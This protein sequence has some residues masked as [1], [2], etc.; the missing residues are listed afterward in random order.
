LHTDLDS[1][2]YVNVNYEAGSNSEFV[3]GTRVGLLSDSW[4]WMN[5]IRTVTA[6]KF[7]VIY[8]AA[9][10]GK[11]T[12]AHEICNQLQ[13]KRMLGA[14]FFFL[15]DDANRGSTAKVVPTI[16]Y[17]LA[18]SQPVFLPYIANAAR[19]YTDKHQSESSEVQFDF[20][21]LIMDPLKEAQAL[22]DSDSGNPIVIVLDA[23]DEADGDLVNL[24]RSLKI[25]AD[26]HERI[27]ILITTRPESA[28][29]KSFDEAEVDAKSKQAVMENIPR[30]DAD[31]DIRIF[32]KSRF[33]SLRC[34]KKLLDTHPDAIDTLT[35]KADRLFIYARTVINYLDHKVRKVSLQ[36]FADILSDD[37]GVVGMPALDILYTT[38]LQDAF[39]DDAMNNR[40]VRL[41]VTAVLAGLVLDGQMIPEVLAPLMGLSEDAVIRTVEEL[42]SVLSCDGEDLQTA[43]IRPHH[44]TF[45]E[46]LVDD[47][48]CTNSAFHIDR[49]ACHLDFAK[50]CLGSLNTILH[51]NLCGWSNDN[52]S[53]SEEERHSLVQEFVPAHTLYASKNWT[54][55]LVKVEQPS[56]PALLRGLD[57][58]CKKNLLPWIEV[59]AFAGNLNEAR[60]MLRD[61]LSWAKVSVTLHFGFTLLK[62]N[63]VLSGTP[64]PRSYFEDSIRRMEIS[65]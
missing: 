9:G 49:R 28:V 13:R 44:L 20:E 18:R 59:R 48:R 22:S 19:E 21:L 43:V 61:A 14:W 64:Q 31:G 8:G 53:K 29:V 32:F 46:F 55:H 39:D 42:R 62:Y 35:K 1:L 65:G 26:K 45:A 63:G 3:P 40:D 37:A 17:Q 36:R 16:A 11:S 60:E 15:H 34:G 38:I 24:L 47:K 56:D 52:S 27:R 7:F 2:S 12:F 51:R 57:E 30:N 58:F 25:L 10:T 50:A 5:D 6:S 33:E 54:A 4:G 23:L 41:R